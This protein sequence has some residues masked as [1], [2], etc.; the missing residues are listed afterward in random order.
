MTESSNYTLAELCIV[1]AA[2]AMKVLRGRIDQYLAAVERNGGL[3]AGLY[4]P[5]MAPFAA[6]CGAMDGGT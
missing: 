1:A 6:A 5:P 2:E 4:R 3:G